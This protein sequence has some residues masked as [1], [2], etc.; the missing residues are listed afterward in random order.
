MVG[1]ITHDGEQWLADRGFGPAEGPIDTIAVG[2]GTTAPQKD[3]DSLYNEVYRADVSQ[4]NVTIER[5]SERGEYVVEVLLS[6]GTNIDP[7]TVIAEYALIASGG[8]V[9]VGREVL[10]GLEIDSGQTVRVAP[11]FDMFP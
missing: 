2:T 7:G 4:S 10:S 3:D 9:F 1:V 6:A 8:P 5:T 11:P